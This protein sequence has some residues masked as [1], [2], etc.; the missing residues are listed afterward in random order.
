VLLAAVVV[1]FLVVGL[2]DLARL[3]WVRISAI[4]SVSFD[5][6][7]RRRVLW[8]TP[9]A[10]VGA[11]VVSQLQNAVDP[12]D[13]IRQTTKI[14]LFATGLVVTLV[15]IILAA[16]NL[17]K[18]IETRVIY[19][20]VTK[21]TTRLEIVLGKVWGFAKV[22]AAILLI[23]GVFTY[24]YLHVR[25]WRLGSAIRR[26]AGADAGRS[27]QPP[28]ARVL[29]ERRL[30][31]AKAMDQPAWL[32][33]LAKP[34]VEGEP[35]WMAGGQGQRFRI[36]FQFAEADR[37]TFEQALG[38]GARLSLIANVPVESRQ[39]TNAE[40]ETIVQTRIPM[41][42]EDGTG[43]PTT[44]PSETPATA[45]AA[46]LAAAA[47]QPATGASVATTQPTTA[48]S[49]ADDDT[50]VVMG[51][52]AALLDLAI[53]NNVGEVL[54]PGSMINKGQRVELPQGVP[55]GTL[56][57]IPLALDPATFERVL[58]EGAIVVGVDAPSPAVRYAIGEQ[59]LV[60]QFIEADGSPGPKFES[61]G[62]ELMVEG[63]V[64]RY[65]Q[66][67]YGG[68][69]GRGGV[70][71]YRF[72]DAHV[73]D[74]EGDQLTIEFK[75][76]IERGGEGLDELETVPE[77]DLRVHDPKT[78]TMSEPVTFRP[79]TNRISYVTLPRSAFPAGGDFDVVVAVRTPG[80]W[81]GVLPQSVSL[82][83]G[84]R[85]FAFNLAK[86]LSILWLLSILVVAIAVFCSTFV[87]WPIAVVLTLVLL[88]G[89]WGVDQIGDVGGPGIGSILTARPRDAVEARI[90][91][92]G[93][94]HAGASL[95]LVAPFLPDISRFQATADNRA[96]ISVPVSRF[97][98]GGGVLLGYGLPVILLAYLILKRK[99][100]AP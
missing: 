82:V 60:L 24:A 75:A 93:R 4:S 52:P 25:A 49:P 38:R 86:S 73:R 100:V 27:R 90:L 14:C 79:E 21:P 17:Q 72:T 68:E 5:E 32:Q 22:S 10:I 91:R 48:P 16:T 67:L 26:D 92:T 31:S 42:G 23:M 64:G 47:T 54:V 44:A 83:T 99:E 2:R 81:L 9:L 61:S 30:L 77:V 53:F 62:R 89:R 37:A 34:P 18:E 7:I 13:A 69:A 70:A 3:S 43:E 85:S 28:D 11:V 63:S 84:S 58:E 65:G 56:V 39:P 55:P 76:G 74:A 80:Q 97:V 1:A 51:R 66:Q 40:L 15:A 98:Q 95:S 78:G 46:A 50:P 29:Q 33:M 6:S 12:Q 8:I 87:S 41:R 35:R 94:R 36:G 59:P 19:T 20:I 96:G 45:P 71:V 57:E 88:L